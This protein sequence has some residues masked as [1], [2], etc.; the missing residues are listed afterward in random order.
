MTKCSFCNKRAEFY[1]K[2]NEKEKIYFC[3][4]DGIKFLARSKE[5]FL[6]RIRK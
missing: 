1:L 3:E 5:S 6:P 4:N 2:K